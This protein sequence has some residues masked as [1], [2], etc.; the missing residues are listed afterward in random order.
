MLIMRAL[1]SVHTSTAFN[2]FS[3]HRVAAT[4]DTLAQAAKEV[5]SRRLFTFAFYGYMI[6]GCALSLHLLRSR[7]LCAASHPTDA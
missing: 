3:A 4:I 7:V 1:K 6:Q 2:N 5:S